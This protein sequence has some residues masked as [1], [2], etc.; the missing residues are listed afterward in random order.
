MKHL[1]F[2]FVLPSLTTMTLT[3]MQRPALPVITD[4]PAQH[5]I[6]VHEGWERLRP[7]AGH[8]V[9]C[10][11]AG[12]L[13]FAADRTLVQVYDVRST[14][15]FIDGIPIREKPAFLGEAG[16]KILGLPSTLWRIRPAETEEVTGITDPTHVADEALASSARSDAA[17]PNP[18]YSSTLTSAALPLASIPTPTL[19]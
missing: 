9:H 6:I 11:G 18:P 19:I 15:A 3:A 5:E 12:H 17:N 8:S 4:E 13:Q 7:G 14:A 2:L 10:I 1:A 16:I